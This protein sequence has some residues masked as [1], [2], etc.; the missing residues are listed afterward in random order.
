M[1][2]VLLLLVCVLW[3]GVLSTAASTTTL[4]TAPVDTF[5]QSSVQGCEDTSFRGEKFADDDIVRIEYLEAP[6]FFQLFKD[7]LGKVDL[8]HA[9][10]AIIN[11]KTGVEFVA[12][13][14]A[15]FEVENAT[16]PYVLT[17]PTTGERYME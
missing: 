2:V 4:P 7:L 3:V 16:F 6:L 17:N 9:G 5:C 11:Q 8:Y 10:L 12:S 14:E 13:F 1:R 15:L